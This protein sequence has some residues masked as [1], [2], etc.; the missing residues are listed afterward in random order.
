MRFGDR[1]KHASN[2]W[3]I[4]TIL[5]SIDVYPRRLKV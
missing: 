3:S 2:R 5:L 4:K 1:W